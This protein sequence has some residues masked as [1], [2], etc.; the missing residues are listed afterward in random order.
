MKWEWNWVGL[1]NNFLQSDP[2]HLHGL[3]MLLP[4]SICDAMSR[5]HYLK[6]LDSCEQIGSCNEKYAPRYY[7]KKTIS[8]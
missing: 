7:R 4:D 1:V 3:S 8:R 2:I 6:L 5:H